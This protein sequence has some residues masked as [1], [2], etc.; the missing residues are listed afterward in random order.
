MHEKY[1]APNEKNIFSGIF[2]VHGG[3]GHDY[4]YVDLLVSKGQELTEN[5]CVLMKKLQFTE[6]Y[7]VL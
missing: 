1:F 7:R 4:V 5:V 6:V 2:H 3:V